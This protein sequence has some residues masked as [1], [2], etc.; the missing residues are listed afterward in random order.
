[1]TI[2]GEKR[3]M[4]KYFDKLVK[5]NESL[6]KEIKDRGLY[7]EGGNEDEKMVPV[8][9]D[10]LTDEQKKKIMIDQT[11]EAGLDVPKDETL[12][13]IVKDPD[14]MKAV[15]TIL[16]GED[17]TTNENT[18]EIFPDDQD[19]RVYI[20]MDDDDL[21]MHGYVKEYEDK[22]TLVDDEKDAAVFQHEEL[23]QDK[24]DGIC[25]RFH[26]DPETFSTQDVDGLTDDNGENWVSIDSSTPGAT[27]I[28]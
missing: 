2:E 4:S 21:D 20:R 14:A 28:P 15:Q 26:Y 25:Y 6:T 7:K 8:S 13:E 19:E 9:S 22:L 17:G 18:E 16:G 1:M 23:A 10:A 5:M 11:K 3:N 12:N 27:T 24:I